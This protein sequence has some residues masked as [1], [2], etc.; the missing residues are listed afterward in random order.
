MHF[1]ALIIHRGDRLRRAIMIAI[2]MIDTLIL[3]VILP[4]SA[5]EIIS[6]K[7]EG[8]AR[9]TVGGPVAPV[10]AITAQ[11]AN[12]IAYLNSGNSE[13][14]NPDNVVI[15]VIHVTSMTFR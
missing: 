2:I 15:C 3:I 6:V 1:D 4:E 9:P 14:L 13:Y 11:R 12:L 8:P 10:D 7:Q 5:L